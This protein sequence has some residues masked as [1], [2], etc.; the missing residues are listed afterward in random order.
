MKAFV[1][2]ALVACVAL[3]EDFA[4]LNMIEGKN[5][6]NAK[7]DFKFRYTS[8]SRSNELLGWMSASVDRSTT[9]GKELQE[10]DMI[11]AFGVLPVNVPPFA[12]VVF[13]KGKDAV[14]QQLPIV[15][16]SLKSGSMDAQLKESAVGVSVQRIEEIDSRGNTIRTHN[17]KYASTSNHEDKNRMVSLVSWEGRLESGPEVTVS[18]ITTAESGIIK[19][20]ETPVSTRTLSMVVEGKNFALQ[21]PENHLRAELVFFV[22]SGKDNFEENA[23]VLRINETNVYAATAL[24]AIVDNERTEVKLSAHPASYNMPPDDLMVK[25]LGA[26]FDHQPSTQGLSVDFPVGKTNFVYG[27][28]VGAGAIIY[29]AGASTAVLSLLVVLVS[30]LLAL[31]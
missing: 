8:T 23:Q 9:T 5:L 29:K 28:A 6:T 1:I 12:L 13:G 7:N 27:P 4:D 17:I 20:G 25:I 10:G 2:L 19:Y 30:A 22:G 15:M 16:N 3:G 31:F 11:M 14:E 21:A 26:A 18:F 24:H